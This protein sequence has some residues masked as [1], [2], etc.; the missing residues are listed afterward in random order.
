MVVEGKLNAS[1]AVYE[2]HPNPPQDLTAAL[3]A[4][5]LDFW[6]VT[7]KPTWQA[8]EQLSQQATCG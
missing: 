2:A 7:E 4:A 5:E 6:K 3:L 8:T 1:P